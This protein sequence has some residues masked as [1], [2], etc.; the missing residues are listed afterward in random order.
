MVSSDVLVILA[1]IFAYLIGTLLIGYLAWRRLEKSVGDLFTASQSLG[2]V[3]TALGIFGTQVTAFGMMGAPGSSY[4]LGYSA[5]GYIVGMAQFMAAAAF[6]VIG[7]RVWLLAEKF[8][9]VTPVHFFGDRF[10]SYLPRFVISIAQIIYEIQYIVIGGIGAGIIFE[11]TTDGVVPYWLG[12]LI[13]L[14]ITTWVAYAGGQRGSA[15]TNIFQGALM[16]IV[17]VPFMYI[18]YNALGGGQAI[19]N[20]LPENMISLG[21]AAVQDPK[22]WIP[23]SL[24]A[25]GLS[26]GVIAHVLVKNMSA[27]SP[28]TIKRN[29][30]IYPALI[31]V[32]FFMTISL[33]VWGSIAIPGLEG[34]AVDRILPALA[35]Q[36][37][38]TWMVGLIAAGIFA[39]IMTSWDGM[40][41]ATSSMFSDDLIKPIARIRGY[42]LSEE[43]EGQISHIFIIV[44][45]VL[46]YI[47][48]LIRPDTILAVGVFAFTG[49]ATMV[50]SYV[51][52]LYWRRT[53]S[54]GVVAS[55]VITTPVVV[56][57]A[58]DILPA[59]TTFGFHYSAPSLI[60]ATVIVIVVSLLTSPPSE[61]R[62]EETF[63]VFDR[64]YQD[65]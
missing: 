27:D 35:E 36:F 63:E 41:L 48:V 12:A 2:L 62:I 51:A 33:G 44:I 17:L 21:G 65:D 58:F 22:I 16:L 24:I 1:I 28:K 7:Y 39:A 52:A 15:W 30:Y 23:F 31:G 26:N 49:F 5:Y 56:M 10:D 59:W 19:L 57:W 34:N 8:G 46:T 14:F 61:E 38:P 9:H 64:V 40:L 3:A 55:V 11:V 42:E 43:L 4:S 29:T 32:L 54:W 45:A 13:I 25:T 37:A 47:L 53:T 6:F 20:Q 50:P 60:L 18:V